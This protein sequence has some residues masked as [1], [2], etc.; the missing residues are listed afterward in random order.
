[1]SRRGVARAREPQD[2]A[3]SSDASEYRLRPFSVLWAFLRRDFYTASTYR[4]TFA[5]TGVSNAT[6]LFFL[7][8]L[9][10]VVGGSK[11]GLYG[12]YFGFAV[13]GTSLIRILTQSMSGYAGR[14][15]SDQATGTF[16]ALMATPA[17]PWFT[18]MC[19]SAYQMLAST[20]FEVITVLVATAFGLRFHVVPLGVPMAI[21]A[22]ALSVGLFS[23][24]GIVIAAWAVMF[25]RGAIGIVSIVASVFTLLGGAMYPVSVLPP[26]IR[27]LSHLVPMTW[28]LNVLRGTLLGAQLPVG[29]LGLLLLG[30]AVT[31]PVAI[32][33]FNQAL[34]R[35]RQGGTLG[36]Y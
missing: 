7:F 1:M 13:I 21:A 3:S 19:G 23:A 4:T 14:L 30:T 29:D 35:A 25:K 10:R 22:L 12:S 18:V 27:A 11:P 28:A 8:F 20:I 36:Q 34:D 15:Q 2:V 5:L 33:A 31:F 32:W 17:P 6:Q 16:E 9:S 26:G 24:I